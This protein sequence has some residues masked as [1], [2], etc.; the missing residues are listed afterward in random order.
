MN[1]PALLS[2]IDDGISF[3]CVLNSLSI[4]HTASQH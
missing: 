4:S 1:N 3:K 2:V